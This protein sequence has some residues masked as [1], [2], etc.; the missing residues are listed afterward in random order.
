MPANGETVHI[1]CTSNVPVDVSLN[2]LK[3]DCTSAGKYVE[4]V[5]FFDGVHICRNSLSQMFVLSRLQ[6]LSKCCHLDLLFKVMSP[7][8]LLMWHSIANWCNYRPVNL[9]FILK[10]TLGQHICAY[11]PLVTLP[12]FP[13]VRDLK[14]KCLLSIISFLSILFKKYISP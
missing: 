7:L 14:W 1:P 10:D 13:R 9:I 6:N 8:K 4:V 3:R 5:R 2:L 11:W 12:Q